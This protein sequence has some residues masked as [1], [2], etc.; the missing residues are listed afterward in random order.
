MVITSQSVQ[1]AIKVR[2]LPNISRNKGNKTIKSGQLTGYNKKNIFLKNHAENVT[3]RLV[4]ELFLFFK[5]A[6]YEVTVSP[7]LGVQ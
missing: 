1:Q 7:Q 3:G 6:L 2:I 5:K 4:S